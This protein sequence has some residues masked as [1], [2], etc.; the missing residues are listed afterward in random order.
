MLRDDSH[1]ASTDG[2]GHTAARVLLADGHRILVH[3]RSQE[4]GEPVAKA[5]SGDVAAGLRRGAD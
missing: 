4:R 2:I 1:A 5:L 3:E